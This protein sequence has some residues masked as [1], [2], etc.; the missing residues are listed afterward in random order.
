MR[1]SIAISVLGLELF[2]SSAASAANVRTDRPRLLFGNRTGF[3][4]TVAQLI[5][6]CSSNELGIVRDWCDAALDG[7]TKDKL[8]QRIA[9]HATWIIDHYGKTGPSTDSRAR[10]QARGTRLA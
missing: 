10:N 8:E 1:A 7:A 5:S 6:R 4:T 9:N 3:G 2:A